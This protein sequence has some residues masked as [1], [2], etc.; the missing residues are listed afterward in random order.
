[1][2]GEVL[3]FAVN[4]KESFFM[5]NNTTILWLRNE[6]RS[7]FE[8]VGRTNENA[9]LALLTA[10]VGLFYFLK[11]QWAGA[12]WNFFDPIRYSSLSIV[13][14]GSALYL[15]F[16]LAEWK[17][18]WKK[19]IPLILIAAVL[20]IYVY[21][22]SKKMSTNA[23]GVVMDVFFCVMAYKKNFRKILKCM[24]GVSV[25]MLFIAGI[26]VPLGFTMD[27]GKPDTSLP[28]HSMGINYPNSW[29][30][31]VFLGLIILWYLYLRF[32]PVITCIVFWPISVFMYS[33]I[34]CRTIAG[35]TLIFPVFAF[36]VD[37]LEKRMDRKADE[38]TLKRNKI[39]EWT[40]T[41]IPFI[42]WA[43]MMFSSYQVSWWYKFY[44]GP[45][46]NL[47]W[48]FIQGGLYFRT[49]GLPLVGNPYRSN[50]ITYVNVEDEFI[51]VGILDSSFAAY[52]IMRGI[53]WLT[54]TL[55]WLCVAHYKA[56]KKRDYAIILLETFLL[57]FAMM[58]R[59][60]L[61][62]WYN[63][64]LLYPLAAVASK[65]WT[66]KVLEFEGKVSAVI[67]SS[68][69]KLI[70]GYVKDYKSF[71]KLDSFPRYRFERYEAA[72]GEAEEGTLISAR[73]RYDFEKKDHCL[74]V[75]ENWNSEQC[76]FYH[77][78]TCMLDNQEYVRGDKEA[79]ENGR[80]FSEYHAA[81][82]QLSYLL[83]FS[84]I[85]DTPDVTMGSKLGTGETAA[86]YLQKKYE[87][88]RELLSGEEFGAS[89]EA[90]KAG[91]DA[92]YSFLGSRS[93]CE[94]YAHD[95]DGSAYDYSVFEEK[96]GAEIFKRI[97]NHM[98]GRADKV[99]FNICKGDYKELISAI[100]P[101]IDEAN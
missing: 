87:A 90:T 8:A 44:H 56:L 17:N 42:A 22:F 5:E 88:A 32:K 74:Q 15:L 48:R 84:S 13:M 61:E 53:I 12:A 93:V 89:E 71:M 46:R 49:Y 64:I 60:G 14:W 55:L 3:I 52:I 25:V 98:H 19:T 31:L 51:Q 45:L 68:K 36:F 43:V 78:L 47:A 101:K 79:Y 59:P 83:G 6:V 24:L 27:V 9:Y 57:G 82:V 30:Y 73:T 99:L 28:G 72:E 33:Y 100:G 76:G 18:L 80:G 62:M 63:F 65:P 54:Y 2:L 20:L 75:P 1:M 97:V 34:I 67:E 29:G 91:I 77:E 7:F 4:R 26:G 70:K 92:F 58:E 21:F 23:Y 85:N 95:F 69:S 66:E 37:A 50:K 41:L 40:A 81:Q 16:V 38:G 86:E 96:I 10:Y 94:M 11:I 35:L 39:I